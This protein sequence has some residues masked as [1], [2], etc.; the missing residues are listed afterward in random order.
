MKNAYA[1]TKNVTI[2][3]NP[4]DGSTSV[5]IEQTAPRPDEGLSVGGIKLNTDLPWCVDALAVLVLVALVYIVKKY[6]D[7]WFFDKRNKP[8]QTPK[9]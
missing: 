9:I 5:M 8:T 1:Q 2:D 4:D 3:T 6:I 7:K